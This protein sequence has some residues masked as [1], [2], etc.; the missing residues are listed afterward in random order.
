MKRRRYA[1]VAAAMQQL[2]NSSQSLA[3]DA[4]DTLEE[5]WVVKEA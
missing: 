5:Q 2:S 3:Q 1:A 4:L